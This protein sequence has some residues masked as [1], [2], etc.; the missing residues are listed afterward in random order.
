MAT[1]LS[2]CCASAADTGFPERWIEGHTLAAEALGKPLL[3]EEFGQ[4]AMGN[5][6]NLT[7]VRDPLYKC[8]MRLMLLMTKY[9]LAAACSALMHD[10]IILTAGKRADS[11]GC[12][13]SRNQGILFDLLGGSHTSCLW[14]GLPMALW[15]TALQRTGRCVAPC[16]GNGSRMTE[17]VASVP[18]PLATP[19]G[20]KSRSYV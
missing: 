5:A 12:L 2:S 1:N 16:S 4:I 9:A 10:V 3:L 6:A 11:Y 8:S 13:A 18:S 19:P 17:V 14:P 20:S 15:P 7:R